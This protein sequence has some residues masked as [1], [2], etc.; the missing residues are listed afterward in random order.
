MSEQ[1]ESGPNLYVRTHKVTGIPRGWTEI[2]EDILA[3][4]GEYGPITHYVPFGRVRQA[5]H[6]AL[7]EASESAAFHPLTA[8]ARIKMLR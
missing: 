1:F 6:E 5:R 8:A 2:A 3:D 7:Q 4:D